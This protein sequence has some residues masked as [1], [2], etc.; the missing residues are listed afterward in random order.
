MSKTNYPNPLLRGGPN[1]KHFDRDNT[2][3]TALAGSST[4]TG[5]WQLNTAPDVA[6]SYDLPSNATII[7][8]V[9][10]DAGVNVSQE[11]IYVSNET[12]VLYRKKTSRYFRLKV[13]NGSQDAMPF[14]RVHTY[15]GDFNVKTE[16]DIV[17]RGRG[18]GSAAR[19]PILEVVAP[20]L[21][22]LLVN[23]C[24]LL[25]VNNRHLSILTGDTIITDDIED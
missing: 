20:A 16:D 7:L 10:D 6:I 23:L 25:K 19:P 9:S 21:E 8:Q 1:H 24:D 22:E 13:L 18:E 2:T 4:F 17:L 14:T 11:A 15:Y 5:E 3:T 12:D